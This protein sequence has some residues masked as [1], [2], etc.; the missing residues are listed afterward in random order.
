MNFIYSIWEVSQKREGC[1]FEPLK[2]SH[3]NA[4]FIQLARIMQ[5]QVLLG[6][7]MLLSIYCSF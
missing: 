6:V 3:L 1:A 2:N 5:L 4:A 7:I